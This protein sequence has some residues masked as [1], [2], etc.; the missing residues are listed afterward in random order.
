MSKK[1]IHIEDVGHLIVIPCSRKTF[2]KNFD[3]NVRSIVSHARLMRKALIGRIH[4]EE[5]PHHPNFGYLHVSSKDTTRV[6]IIIIV[7]EIDTKNDAGWKSGEINAK[8][9]GSGILQSRLT[10][11]YDHI[12]YKPKQVLDEPT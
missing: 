9:P 3:S 10:R 5:S 8:N 7:F 4:T 12:F 6:L 1:Y 2:M 11:C